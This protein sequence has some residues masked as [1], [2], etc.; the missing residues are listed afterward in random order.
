MSIG[1]VVAKGS[2]QR[3]GSALSLADYRSFEEAIRDT[4]EEFR[5]R[6]LAWG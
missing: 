6:R 2:S 4:K 1:H 3:G 5:E